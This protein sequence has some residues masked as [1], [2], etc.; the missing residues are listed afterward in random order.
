MPCDSAVQYQLQCTRRQGSW[1]AVRRFN[2][3]VIMEMKSPE[4]APYFVTTL[5]ADA[6][7]AAVAHAGR[8]YNVTLDDL[9][10]SWTGEFFALWPM[11][12]Q[13]RRGLRNGANE[14]AVIELRKLLGVATRTDLGYSPRFDDTLLRTL[15]RFQR[16]YG[17]TPDGIAG[18]ATWLM[19]HRAAGYDIPELVG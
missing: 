14:P 11:P 15:V 10:A 6:Q 4:G 12:E 19:L 16:D 13:Y 18:P 3:P 17:L 9:L 5:A 8:Y 7:R 1:D 2:V